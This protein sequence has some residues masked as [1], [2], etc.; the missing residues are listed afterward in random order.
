MVLKQH[1]GCLDAPNQRRDEDNFEVGNLDLLVHSYVVA[2]H[3]AVLSEL[4]VD[5]L[6]LVLRVLFSAELVGVELGLSMSDG[7]QAV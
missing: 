6:L 3:E 2:L 4:T 7:Y 5:V 1:E